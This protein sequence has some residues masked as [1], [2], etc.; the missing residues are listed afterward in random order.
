VMEMARLKRRIKWLL[1]LVLLG[2]IAYGVFVFY[3]TWVNPIANE[4]RQN[5]LAR[6]KTRHV[7][8]LTYNEIPAPFRNA[9]ISTEDRS[10]DTNIGVDPVGI[11]RSLFVDVASDKFTQGGSTI[12]QQLVRG[13]YLGQTE[14]TLKRKITEAIFS[15]GLARTMS[16]EDIFMLYTNDIYYGEGAYGLYDA[17]QTY[18]GRTPQQ[19][20][21]AELALLA[22]IPNAPSAYDPFHALKLAQERQHDVVQNMV[23]DGKIT[24]AQADQILAQPLRLKGQ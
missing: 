8:L 13:A 9:I 19:L 15:M 4:V 6:A 11:V 10:F 7:H 22:G 1:G 21:Q 23:E 3:F 16:K 2:V 5:V 12:T 24:Q 20:N 17:A 18:F 14:K